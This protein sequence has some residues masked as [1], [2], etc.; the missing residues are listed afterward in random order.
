VKSFIQALDRSTGTVQWTDTIPSGSVA[1]DLFVTILDRTAF[2]ADYIPSPLIGSKT[3]YFG[4]KIL[5]RAY[6]I[7]TGTLL[8]ENVWAPGQDN[9]PQ[10]IVASR[11]AVVVVGYGGNTKNGFLHLIVR[12]YEP[13][14]G[15]TLWEDEQNRSSSGATAAWAA[16]IQGNRVFV[17]GTIDHGF[18]HRD[19]LLRAYNVSSGHLKWEIQRASTSGFKLSSAPGHLLLA[20]LTST[21]TST[22]PYIAAYDPASG[23]LLWQDEAPVEGFFRSVEVSDH[24]VVAAGAVVR[25]YNL[26]TGRVNWE[27][28]LEVPA[29]DTEFATAVV[30]DART[31]YVCGATGMDLGTQYFWVRAYNRADGRILWDD[32]SHPGFSS[33]CANLALGHNQLFA[34]GSAS[35]PPRGFV[36]RVYDTRVDVDE[37]HESTR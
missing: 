7:P 1:S 26:R 3:L 6:D 4:S 20:G 5:V 33:W 14:T 11:A 12:A 13:A 37:D 19:L 10:G 16:E 15:D 23:A 32:R 34:V 24:R 31:A 8:W 36:V 17:A 9:V 29:G 18:R 28:Q 22:H 30:L 35:D 21:S 25:A 2:I 27:D